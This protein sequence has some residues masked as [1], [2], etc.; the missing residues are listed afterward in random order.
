M[1]EEVHFNGTRC[2][3]HYLYRGYNGN[4]LSEDPVAVAQ[5]K[6]IYPDE[7]EEAKLNICGHY[8]TEPALP[9]WEVDD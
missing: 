6:T 8:N 1:I 7:D 9:Q 2:R 3:I 4:R 5:G